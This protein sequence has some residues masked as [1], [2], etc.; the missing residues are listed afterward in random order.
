ML[1]RG[2]GTICFTAGFTSR[3]AAPHHAASLEKRAHTYLALPST[4]FKAVRGRPRSDSIS[5]EQAKRAATIGFTKHIRVICSLSCSLFIWP[6]RISMKL[7]ERRLQ[8]FLRFLDELGVS[9]KSCDIPETR[10]E[11]GHQF[12]RLTLHSRER[13]LQAFRAR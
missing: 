6:G 7:P 2:N 4:F 12:S 10:E 13:R 3:S 8:A 5:S 11:V 1:H 9:G